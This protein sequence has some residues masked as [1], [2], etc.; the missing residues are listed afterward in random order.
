MFKSIKSSFTKFPLSVQLNTS[1]AITIM[2][3]I[4]VAGYQSIQL[5]SNAL[6]KS[7]HTALD[8]KVIMAT[9]LLS[10]PFKSLTQV[11]SSMSNNLKNDFTGSLYIDEKSRININ[12]NNVATMFL[13]DQ[14]V[15]N[16]FT[17]VDLFSR[18]WKAPATVFQRVNDDFLRVSTSLKKQ[19]G[20]RAF[21]T[22]LG[23]SHPGY[24]KLVSGHSYVGYAKLFG[25][26]FITQ[27]E[28]VV[29]NGSVIAILF[30]GV[31]VTNSI[32]KAFDTI[33]NIKIGQTGYLFIIDGKG[34]MVLHPTIE[35]G[36]PFID[37]KTIDGKTPFRQMINTKQGQ[38]R[39]LWKHQNG[40]YKEKYISYAY[41]S[42]WDWIISGGT[43]EDEFAE[44]SDNMTNT[45][46]VVYLLGTSFVIF[47]GVLTAKRLLKSLGYL[48]DKVAIVGKGDLVQHDLNEVHSNS[49]NEVHLIESS[50]SNMVQS[51]RSL[52]GDISAIGK[53]VN[54]ISDTVCNNASNQQNISSQLSLE[55]EQSATAIEQLSVSFREVAQ[56]VNNA[57]DSSKKI[58]QYTEETSEH[59]TKLVSAAESMTTRIEKV[60]HSINNLSVNAQN[61]QQA[62]ELIR[63]IA[64][65]TN[66]LALNAAIEAARAGEQGKGFAVVADEVRSLAQR[67]QGSIN[68]I[69]QVVE[70]FL[71][72]TSSAKESMLATLEETQATQT[73]ATESSNLLDN[74]SMMVADMNKELA[75]IAAAVTEQ[76]AVSDDIA[77]R[78]NEVNQRAMMSSEEA[79]HALNSANQLT[80]LANKLKT[81][82]LRFNA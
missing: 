67:T 50:M 8:K 68:E 72:S 38:L 73:Q 10:T 12:G 59:M 19:D 25:K 35:P 4:L 79:H 31:D 51:L 29:V 76:S 15:T 78:Q 71:V 43:F 22:W 81:S 48:V 14:V 63:G 55:A 40:D 16:D 47:I 64:E 42:D 39:Y 27:Y 37:Q 36:S 5:A 33:S 52:V 58:D 80:D 49:N 30:V 77:R 3:L 60:G 53:E 44:A 61:I 69:E 75:S 74:V 6:Y 45:L 20:S 18:N 28:P 17:K 23:K 62:V 70:Q 24:K 32:Q 1:I 41:S 26:H 65:Q 21:G 9:E 13:D 56:N 66:L 11:V 46:I 57:A 7:E 54:S 82:L 2:L 34:R